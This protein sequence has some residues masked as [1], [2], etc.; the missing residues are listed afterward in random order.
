MLKSCLEA[1]ALAGMLWT[2]P[3]ASAAQLRPVVASEV[4]VS[5]REA[6]LHLGFGDGGELR[7]SFKEGEVRVDG[8]L[9]GRYT[10][11]DPLDIAWRE[12][13]ADVLSLDDGPLAAAL[14]AWT[15][16]A[17][18][19]GASRQLAELLDQRLEAALALPTTPAAPTAP[20]A[21]NPPPSN[22][23]G[24]L[25]QRAAVLERL[26]RAVE[27]VELERAAIHLDRDVTVAV[28]EVVMGPLVVVGGNVEVEGKVEGDVVVVDGSIRI[29]E[30]GTVTGSVRISNGELR[31]PRTRVKGEVVILE[32]QGALPSA[33]KTSKAS[34]ERPGSREEEGSSWF[35][36]PF[37]ALAKTV[38]GLLQ[39]VGAFLL[40]IL[41]GAGAIHFAGDRLERVARAARS[42]PGRGLGVGL[43]G[44]FLLLP[45][46]VMGMVALVL[47]IIGI[48]LLL[49]WIPF[50][51]LAAFFTMGFGYLAVARNV[52][53][54]VVSQDFR[55]LERLSPS[56]RLHLLAAGV[57][58]LMV[59]WAVAGAA[60]LLGGG[61]VRALALLV[62]AG[63]TW[64]AVSLGFGAVL[65]TR[66]GQ[67]P[68][69][70]SFGRDDE[71]ELWAP[72]APFETATPR[73]E[74][75]ESGA[76]GAGFGEGSRV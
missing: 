74:S 69:Y 5:G 58:V 26:T 42:T 65:L 68:P 59:P 55:G 15:P 43:A 18:L 1:A 46:W 44:L 50:F 9:V 70:S 33:E 10:R 36:A 11:G 51:P 64:L 6:S 32:D 47:S 61:L 71:D 8:T 35:L 52:G 45:A 75:N 63:A 3:C 60:H 27:G 16:P 41:F 40:L 19:S 72:G 53:E 73:P 20:E 13:L 17:A 14:V 2:L 12:L 7:V 21:P 29:R 66:L 22:L 23:L 24:V 31:G 30:G 28:G 38:T 76:P 37:R 39:T 67:A 25:L 34:A 4:A 48:P 57:A 54:W 56:N 62:A 49:V